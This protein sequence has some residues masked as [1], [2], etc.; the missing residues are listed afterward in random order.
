MAI[1]YISRKDTIQIIIPLHPRT[2][3]ILKEKLKP[4]LYDSVKQNEWIKIILPV[5]YLDM[6]MLEKNAKLIMTDSG[7]VQKES[8]FFKKPCII[9]RPETEWTELVR[10]GT[11]IIADADTS[12]IIDSY[13]FFKTNKNF[14]F[15]PFFG[16]GNAA[17]FICKKII[18]NF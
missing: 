6:I 14:S 9:L 2:S 12:K 4:K 7:G 5:S 17:E 18:K 10:N 13:H 3:G 11:A 15:P 16:D 1:D 8:H